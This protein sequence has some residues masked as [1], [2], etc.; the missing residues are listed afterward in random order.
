MLEG[1]GFEIRT[2]IA[3]LYARKEVLA[4]LIV[5]WLAEGP[6]PDIGQDL[7]HVVVVCTGPAL[8]KDESQRRR[9]T[10]RRKIIVREDE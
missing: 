10:I 3:R 8:P 2:L 1:V 5:S 7:A 9:R 6:P 4:L